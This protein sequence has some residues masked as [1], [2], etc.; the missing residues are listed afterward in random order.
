M[1][2]RFARLIYLP[3][4]VGG[5]VVMWAGIRVAG[6][7]LP[8]GLIILALGAVTTILVARMVL[9]GPAAAKQQ[10]ANGDLTG[11][12]FDYIMWVAL[13]VPMLLVVGLVILAITG[14]LSSR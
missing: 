10:V 4:L 5:I 6:S 14:G 12:Y 11:P 9:R 7:S 2:S 8:V 13:G 3:A 1:G